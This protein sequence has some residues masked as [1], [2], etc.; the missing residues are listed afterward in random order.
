VAGGHEAVDRVSADGE[1]AKFEDL[2]GG[3]SEH[4]VCVDDFFAEVGAPNEV[5]VAVVEDD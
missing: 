2:S 5:D 3:A 1:V 4:D